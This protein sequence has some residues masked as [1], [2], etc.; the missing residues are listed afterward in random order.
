MRGE[1]VKS[2]SEPPF[3]VGIEEEYLLV[4]LDSRDVDENPP[5]PLLEECTRRSGRQVNPRFLRCQLEASTQIGR[6][7]V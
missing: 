5:A 1:D 7:H 4:N 3:T 6:A 2:S